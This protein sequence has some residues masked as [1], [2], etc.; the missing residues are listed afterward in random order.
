MPIRLPMRQPPNFGQQG[1]VRDEAINRENAKRLLGYW[2][3]FSGTHHDAIKAAGWKLTDS[4]TRGKDN[5]GE[6]T[7]VVAR[8][9]RF[10]V[11]VKLDGKTSR[12]GYDGKEFWS[13]TGDEAAAVVDAEKLCRNPFAAQ[14]YILAAVQTKDPLATIGKVLIDAGDKANKQLAYRLKAVDSDSDEL[15]VWLSVLD[16]QGRPQ[17]RLLKTSETEGDDGR[18]LAVVYDDWKDVGG[19]QFPHTRRVVTGLGEA[20]GLVIA[21]R[22]VETLEQVEDSVFAKQ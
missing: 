7:I 2:R 3:E 15:F 1:E 10:H 22:Q 6:Q 11:E 20:V 13:A 18:T 8:D 5:V 12:F 9:G 16:A 21:A 4:I 14:G 19:V 17:V